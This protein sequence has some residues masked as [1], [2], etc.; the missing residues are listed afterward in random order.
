MTTND[1]ATGKYESLMFLQTDQSDCCM[2]VTQCPFSPIIQ[3][4]RVH[5][6]LDVT[7]ADKLTS[8]EVGS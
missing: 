2:T 3:I 7:R 8:E 1:M 4:I 5:A 6:S